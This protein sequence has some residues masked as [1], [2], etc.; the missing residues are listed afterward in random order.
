MEPE[1][2][3]NAIDK[4]TDYVE[5]NPRVVRLVWGG[6]SLMLITHIRDTRHRNKHYIRRGL[7]NS[8]LDAAFTATRGNFQNPDGAYFK[9]QFARKGR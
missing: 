6:I 2:I 3:K 1:E 9:L 4:A 8:M 5:K 7:A